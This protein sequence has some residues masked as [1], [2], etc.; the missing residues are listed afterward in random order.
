MQS[1]PIFLFRT[2]P[3]K[4]RGSDIAMHMHKIQTFLTI[5]YVL[6]LQVC[7]EFRVLQNQMLPIQRNTSRYGFEKCIVNP[8]NLH[9]LI[10]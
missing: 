9:L 7:L 2:T 10:P 4:P 6:G 3:S 1:C 8:H 5:E